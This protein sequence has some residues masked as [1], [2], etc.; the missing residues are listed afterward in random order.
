[1]PKIIITKGLPASGKTTWSKKEQE[2][3]PNLVRVNKDDLR[4]MLHNSKWSPFNEK[5]VLRIRNLIIEDCLKSGRNV[6]CDDTN[7]H[8][9]HTETLKQIARKYKSQMEEK[10]FDV[11]VEECIKRDLKRSNSVGHAVIEE[12]Y[13]KYL[14]PK[15]EPIKQNKELPPCIIC[16]L[17]GTLALFGDKNPYERDF[18]ND[19]VNQVVWDILD[20]YSEHIDIVLLSGR[21]DKYRKQTE[22]FLKKNTVNYK[23]LFMRKTGDGRKDFIVKKEIFD[24][25]IRN[26]WYVDF[27]LD[28]RNQVVEMWRSLGLVCLQ[29]AEGNF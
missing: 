25:E 27:V 10:V 13:A 7:L 3:D 20:R 16:D 23:E 14:K 21:Q 8:P 12:M 2:V 9:K 24:N 1:M 26:R 15:V 18:E 29:V 11:S 17:D 22:D 6:V 28:D 19:E 5:Q 4:L